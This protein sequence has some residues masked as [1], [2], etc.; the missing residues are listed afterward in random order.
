MSTAA[1]QL[2]AETSTLSHQPQTVPQRQ[3]REGRCLLWV[4][5][6]EFGPKS[7]HQTGRCAGQGTPGTEAVVPPNPRLCRGRCWALP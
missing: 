6:S 4:A 5:I 1:T 2:Q 7:G 3:L